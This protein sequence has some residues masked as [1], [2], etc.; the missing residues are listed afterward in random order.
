M[1][2][3]CSINTCHTESDHKLEYMAK[4]E[5]TAKFNA[6]LSRHYQKIFEIFILNL[7]FDLAQSIKQHD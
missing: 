5:H 6:Q 4:C 1:N 2:M 7:V 3:N